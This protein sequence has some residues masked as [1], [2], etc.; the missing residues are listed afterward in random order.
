MRD[1]IALF[2]VAGSLS[3]PILAEQSC[4]TGTY[5]LS[6]PTERFIDNG[7]GTV[8]D[9]QAQLMWMRCAAGQEWS[10]GDCVG[11]ASTFDWDA[12]QA[13]A[14]EL[15]ASGRQFFNDWRVPG[16]RELAMIVERQ[17]RDPRINLGI[18]PGTSGEFF[19]TQS[20]RPGDRDDDFAYALSFGAEGVHHLPKRDRNQLRLVRTAH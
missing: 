2:L 19:W 6:T 18:F 14:A 11:T 9:Q 15:N 7:D 20:L 12:A 8:T 16:L 5:P 17:C 4:D 1:A 13:A 10:G 3:G